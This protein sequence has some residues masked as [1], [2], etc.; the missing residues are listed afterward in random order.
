MWG[1]GP[2]ARA[3]PVVKSGV[4]ILVL[5]ALSSQGCGLAPGQ[6]STIMRASLAQGVPPVSLFCFIM[7]FRRV[8]YL[9]E[10][11]Q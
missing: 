7:I 3:G 9:N 11:C 5:L 2:R 6:R 10:L 8:N 1:F 4:G